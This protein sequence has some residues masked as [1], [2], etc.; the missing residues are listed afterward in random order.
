MPKLSLTNLSELENNKFFTIVALLSLIT[1]SFYPFLYPKKAHAAVTQGFVRLDRHATG[2]AISGSACLETTTSGTE[3]NVTITFPV[4]WTISGTA[5]N[6]VANNT[7]LPYD[8]TDLATQ[9][10]MWPG[11]SNSE[12]A[13]S[14][15]GLSVT[16]AGSDL[17]TGTFYCFN[18]S[19]ASSTIGTA[20]NDK[21]GQL[22][23]EGGSPYVD[24]VNWATSVVSSGSDQITV[25]ASVSASMTFSLSGNT[26]ALGTLSSSSTNA[27][28][29]ITQTVSTNARNGW[30]SW[31]KSGTDGGGG[32]GTAGALES[33]TAG[34]A[35]DI[36]SPGSWDGTPET[37]S[38]TGGY[39]L[40]VDTGTGSPT[41]AGE[42]NGGSADAGGH[43]TYNVFRQTAT[44]TTPGS[45]DTVSL[46]VKARSSATTP[47]A[48]DYTDTLTVVAAGSF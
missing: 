31:V 5:S 17:T 23:T 44:K 16:W 45:G 34:A 8:P 30:S 32:T 35:N 24:S 18:F 6:W 36:D 40:D 29:G 43:L 20:G 37:L 41:V 38:S 7:N 27:A 2:A 42:Y 33:V 46:V 21:T 11:I 28:S 13:A 26:A 22:K 10:T 15:N 9:A 48:S 12:A 47:A 4:G 3:T 14:V 19:G 39:V 1:A 25:T